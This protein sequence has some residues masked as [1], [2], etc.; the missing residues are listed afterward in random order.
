MEPKTGQGGVGNVAHYLPKALAKKANVAYFPQRRSIKNAYNLL[1]IYRKFVLRE[2]DVIQFNYV[3]T[4]INGSYMLIKFAKKLGTRTVLNIHGIIQLERKLA[5]R[6][7]AI[8]LMI[9][10][11]A[12]SSCSLADKVVVNTEYMRQ[13]AATWYGIARDKMV[14]IPNGVD[15]REFSERS[16]TI[17]L[18]GDPAILNVGWPSRLKGFDILAQAIAQLRSSLPNIKLHM[19]GGGGDMSYLPL[20]KEKGIEKY[21]VF[22]GMVEHSKLPRYYRSADICVIASRRE[23]F[24]ITLL[25][26]MASGLPVIAS[27]IGSLQEIISNGKDGVLF[28]SEDADDLSKAILALYRDEDLK[29]KIS[30]NALKTATK[31]SWENIAE[32]YISLYK[33]LGK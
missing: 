10:P 27:N 25:E 6:H 1:N 14:V 2:F 30:V 31:Y 17:A 20:L 9:L 8:P 32:K 21:V 4:W 33:S 3:P 11:L 18:D 23:G 29:E 26:A 15:L 19:V 7:G 13:Q 22:H 5:R 28:K 16:H 24:P 12:L